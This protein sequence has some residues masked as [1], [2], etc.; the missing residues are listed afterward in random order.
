MV[1]KDGRYGHYVTDGEINAS[2][3]KGDTVEGLTVQRASELLTERR[4]KGPA[5]KR[6]NRK[7]SATAK[8][9]A[10]R[11]QPRKRD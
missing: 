9:P 10:S 8:P 11:N 5:P 2:L 1:V 7:K 3:R 6:S 4:A